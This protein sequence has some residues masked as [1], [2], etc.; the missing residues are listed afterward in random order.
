MND[1]ARY[2]P[3]NPFT[4]I[5]NEFFDLQHLE[6]GYVELK[7][8]YSVITWQ[9]RI[10]PLKNG[11]NLHYTLYKEHVRTPQR[12]DCASLIN[13]LKTKRVCFM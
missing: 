11:I 8:P 6:V 13:P 3:W 5:K 4:S 10:D 7:K 12:I 2:V 1:P 9:I